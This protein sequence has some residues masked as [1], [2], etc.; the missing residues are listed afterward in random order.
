MK[1][2]GA[3]TILGKSILCTIETTGS[4]SEKWKVI[5]WMEWQAN[6]VA[7]HILMP[8]NT[9]KMKIDQ[10]LKAYQINPKSEIDGYQLEK[11]I[12]ELSEFYGLSKQAVKNRMLELGFSFV[13]DACTYVNGRH[14]TPYSFNSTSIKKN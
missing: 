1:M 6:G 14:V 10:L 4:H 5:D 9:A 7:P 12:A 8:T 3:D 11:M 2:I 13:D